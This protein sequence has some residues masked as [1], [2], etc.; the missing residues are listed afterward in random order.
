MSNNETPLQNLLQQIKLLD[1]NI[2]QILKEEGS[3]N[4]IKNYVTP[5]LL[6]LANSVDQAFQA[7]NSVSQTASVALVTAE[8]TLASEVL[9][10][11]AD[12]SAELTEAFSE[13]LTSLSSKM[14][15]EDLTKAQNIER[16]LAELYDQTESWLSSDEE[17]EEGDDEEAEEEAEEDKE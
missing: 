8:K 3:D 17:D 9:E 12:I 5:I 2:S 14:T 13:L 4:V 11:V 16:L 1:D 10:N 6:A 15:P 7:L